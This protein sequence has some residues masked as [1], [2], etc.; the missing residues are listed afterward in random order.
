LDVSLVEGLRQ[1]A[2]DPGLTTLMSVELELDLPAEESASPLRT[3]HMLAISGEALS[4]AARHANARRVVLRAHRDGEQF[5][6]QIEDDGQG[7]N[8]ESI[9]AGYGLR[10]MRDRAR[11]LGGDLAID[12]EPGSGTRVTLTAPWDETA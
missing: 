7:F 8:T 12:S 4:N 2:S 5:T 11:L 1:Q 6:L 9:E 10:N 3:A